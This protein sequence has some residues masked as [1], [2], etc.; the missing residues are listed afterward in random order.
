MME[1]KET[2]THQLLYLTVEIMSGTWITFRDRGPL[3]GAGS[4][5]GL[6]LEHMRCDYKYLGSNLAGC[7]FY[8]CLHQWS[9]STW[10][11]HQHSRAITVRSPLKL[12]YL[13]SRAAPRVPWRSPIQVLFWP[14]VAGLQCL[15]RNWFIQHGI[16][17]SSNLEQ[18][19]LKNGWSRKCKFLKKRWKS[20]K[21]LF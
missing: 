8:N 20:K 10:D 5:S 13:N 6:S 15:R 17:S 16:S 2:Q 18:L 12:W 9:H 21:V 11:R 19:N 14:I 7:T 3:W 1:K 4:F